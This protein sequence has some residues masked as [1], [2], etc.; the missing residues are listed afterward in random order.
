M[1][2]D[3]PDTTKAPA[4]STERVIRANATFDSSPYAQ[5]GR[6]F[7]AAYT[8]QSQGQRD[9]YDALGYTASPTYN[10]FEARYRRGGTAAAL[11]DKPPKDCWGERPTIEDTSEDD[12]DDEADTPFEQAVETFLRDST[13]PWE[14]SGTPSRGITPGFDTDH[15][16]GPMDV[17]ER[18]DRM[19]RLGRFGLLFIGFADDAVTDSPDG[20]D[21]LAEPVDVNSLGR[22]TDE[23]GAALNDVS[24]LAAYD[25]GRVDWATTQSEYLDSDPASPRYGWPE[26]YLVELTDTGETV[27]VHHSRVIHVVEDPFGTELTSDSVLRRSLN[28]LDDLEK[29][30]GASAEAFWR[31]AYQ[32]FVVSPPESAGPGSNWQDRGEQVHEQMQAYIDNWNRTIFS[33]GEVTQLDADVSSPLD[34]VEAEYREIAAGHDFPQSVLQGNE[35]GERATQ[36]DKAMYHEYIARRRRQFCEETIL[37]PLINRL[38]SFGVLPEPEGDGFDVNWPPLEE[39]SEQEEADVASTKATAV[40]AASGNSPTQMATIP[41]LRQELFGW[42]PEVGSEA[43]DDAETQ[44]MEPLDE[45]DPQV[46]E[47]FGAL[48]GPEPPAEA[49]TDGGTESGDGSE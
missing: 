48:E 20:E 18:V 22:D 33:N 10:H 21:A 25:E 2:S 47:Q 12:E 24:Y 26:H 14:E 34:H 8:S 32:G 16:S 41:E 45:S 3:T 27:E 9:L 37:R 1:S 44:A 30:L 7:D 4:V 46:A 19:S 6:G 38:I 17:A 43:P 49:A 35:T 28:R 40:K 23:N 29:I 13:T 42:S 36:E 11:V 15:T 5:H 31:T 39:M